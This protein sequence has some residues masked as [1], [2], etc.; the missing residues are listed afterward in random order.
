V[1]FNVN[2]TFESP[3]KSSNVTFN[4]NP[5]EMLNI[6]IRIECDPMRT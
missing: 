2:R 3:W 4:V 1:I 6:R 5:G